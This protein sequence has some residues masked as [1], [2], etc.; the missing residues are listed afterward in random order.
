MHE[1]STLDGFVDVTECVAEMIKY[2]ANEPS[3]GL[4]YI[5]QHAQNAVPNVIRLRNNVVNK[6]R[7]TVLHTED[8]EDSIA[9]VRSMK[10]CGFPIADEMIRDIKKSLSIMSAK[11]PKRG[12][13]QDSGSVVLMERAS[14]WGPSSWGRPGAYSQED[15]E[16]SGYFS[17][18]FKSAKKKASNLKWPQLD[19]RELMQTNDEKLI[20]YP[21]RTL[22]VASGASASSSL[23]DVEADE[24][25]LSSQITDEHREEEMDVSS[26]SPSQS[27]MIPAVSEN[28]DEFKANKEAELEEWLEGNGNEDDDRSGARNSGEA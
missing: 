28:Y 22:S 5:Q 3:V 11:Q 26:S 17:T 12:L 18:V 21:E 7:E 27:L 20:F 14:S 1:F 23:Q 8:S 4:F 10:E 9:M 24:L 16:K 15:S 13:I 6:S 25:P 19:S 2:L